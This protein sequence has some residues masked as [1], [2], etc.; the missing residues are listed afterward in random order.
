[1]SVEAVEEGQDTRPLWMGMTALLGLNLWALVCLLPLSLELGAEDGRSW[2]VLAYLFP[3][4][5]LGA[6]VVLRWSW[7]VLMC[8]PGSFLPVFLILPEADQVAHAS[9]G[10]FF[11]LAVS[12]GLF[13]WVG[14]RWSSSQQPLLPLPLGPGGDRRA[15]RL[16]RLGEPQP[17]ALPSLRRNLWWPYQWHFVPRWIMLAVLF[18][19][20]TYNINFREGVEV[21]YA[22]GFGSQ[23]EEARV[24]MNLIFLFV[25]V[26]VAYLYFFVPGINLELEQ[27]SLDASLNLERA[28]TKKRWLPW[29]LVGWGFLASVAALSLFW[30][31][32]VRG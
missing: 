7:A 17:V 3:L 4:V 28:R 26:V 24:L 6:A 14:A 32:E 1:M 9:A 12:L 20:G 15:V 21:L 2:A 18:G 8:F 16:R 22:D 13:V 25:W 23:A 29:R 5:A 31:M 30:W 19:V 10:G 27:R 11:S